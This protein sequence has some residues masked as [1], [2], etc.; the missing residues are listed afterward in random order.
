MSK[1]D[2]PIDARGKRVKIGDKVRGEGFM[3]FHDGFKIDRSPIVE[4]VEDKGVLYFGKLSAKSFP[5]FWIIQ[6][7]KQTP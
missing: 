1:I 6:N 5:K 4:V 2:F 7:N 3:K